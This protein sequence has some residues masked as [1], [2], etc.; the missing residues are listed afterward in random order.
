[1]QDKIG[2]ANTSVVQM[3]RLCAHE[4]LLSEWRVFTE[5]V[6]AWSTT[7]PAKRAPLKTQPHQISN[8]QRTENKATEMVSHQHSR[9]LLMMDILMSETCWAHKR[10]N[11]I[12]S[13]M[14]L[15]FNSS[16]ITMMHGPINIRFHLQFVGTVKL[17]HNTQWRRPT[18]SLHCWSRAINAIL[19]AA[20][21]AFVLKELACDW[22][23]SA[24]V[25]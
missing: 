13:D 18:S 23:L 5:V 24:L 22:R 25:P 19:N 15:V 4:G 6:V 10:W 3:V 21:V 16:T 8:T 12:A 11:K 17:F 7:Q 20:Q 14:K 9:K 2:S 1:M